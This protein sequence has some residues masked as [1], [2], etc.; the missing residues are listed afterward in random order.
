MLLANILVKSDFKEN[1]KPGTTDCD[2]STVLHGTSSTFAIKGQT[3][4]RGSRTVLRV[5]A[6]EQLDT[7]KSRC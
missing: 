1:K 6:G 5:S 7:Q 3:L 4:I 2:L